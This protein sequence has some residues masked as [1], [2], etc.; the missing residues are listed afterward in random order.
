VEGQPV[1]KVGIGDFDVKRIRFLANE[2]CWL[3]PRFI[4]V[5]VQILLQGLYD[6]EPRVRF[7][8]RFHSVAL[9]FHRF[10]H[11][12]GKSLLLS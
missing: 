7:I 3:E 5:F 4:A 11:M 10:I 12:C 1:F 9:D 8:F 6:L 2:G